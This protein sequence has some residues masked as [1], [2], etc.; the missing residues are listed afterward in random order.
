M[1]SKKAIKRGRPGVEDKVN[2][3][4]VYITER[5]KKGIDKKFGTLTKAVRDKVLPECG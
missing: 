4:Y 5:Q 1:K 3:Y 2:T